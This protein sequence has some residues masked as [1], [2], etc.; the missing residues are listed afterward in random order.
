MDI[1]FGACYLSLFMS[2]FCLL[3]CAG[4]LAFEAAYENLPRFHHWVDKITGE[5]S[6]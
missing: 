5:N 2:G 1:L 6:N 4:N 3:L